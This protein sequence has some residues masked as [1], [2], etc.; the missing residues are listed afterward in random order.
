MLKYWLDSIDENGYYKYLYRIDDLE[1]LGFLIVDPSTYKIID[2]TDISDS[3]LADGVR[4]AYTA[5]RVKQERSNMTDLP[6]E[7]TAI[8]F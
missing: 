2:H 8:W 6:K 5:M 1:E 4:H 3:F 7:G